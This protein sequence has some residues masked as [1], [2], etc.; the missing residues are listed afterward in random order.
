M[1]GYCGIDLIK[2]TNF[3]INRSK[4]F[5]DPET[6]VPINIIEGTW[7]VVKLYVPKRYRISNMLKVICLS[8]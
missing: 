2:Y 5:K 7:S 8:L 4:Y 1:E 3:T 6:G